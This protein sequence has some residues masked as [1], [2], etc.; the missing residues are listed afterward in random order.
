MGDSGPSIFKNQDKGKE[1]W[2]SAAS[3]KR[4]KKESKSQTSEDAIDLHCEV[5]RNK[6]RSV[7]GTGAASKPNAY[8]ISEKNHGRHPQQNGQRLLLQ[9]E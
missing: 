6:K 3:T 9:I 7:Y 8:A 1:Q 5:G 2:P 4:V